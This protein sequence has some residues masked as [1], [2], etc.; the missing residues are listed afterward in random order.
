VNRFIRSLSPY[1]NR[2]TIGGAIL[3]AIIL[4]LVL[5]GVVYLSRRSANVIQDPP[6]P[7]VAIIPAP[8]STPSPTSTPQVTPTAT[9]DI[10]PSP[11]PGTFSIGSFV[12]ISGTGGDGLRLRAGAGLD[13]PVG[14]LGLESEVF[15]IVDGPLEGDGYTWYLL[16]SPYDEGQKRRGWAVSNYLMTVQNP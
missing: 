15:L 1:L 7:V 2:L 12:Q 10:P 5:L 14:F 4:F 16:E 13:Q 9:V 11:L 3:T 8:T 6:A